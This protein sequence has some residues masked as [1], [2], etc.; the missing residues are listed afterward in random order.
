MKKAR[1]N[2]D[3]SYSYL[4]GN[5]LTRD[6]KGKATKDDANMSSDMAAAGVRQDG[7]GQYSAYVCYEF[8][9]Q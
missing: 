8:E 4:G 1:S 2:L 6:K 5:A 3:S 7:D 9:I